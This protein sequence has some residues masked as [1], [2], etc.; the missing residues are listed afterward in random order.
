MSIDA[1]QL[2][3][4]KRAYTA[5]GGEFV[6]R[7]GLSKQA[8]PLKTLVLKNKGRDLRFGEVEPLLGVPAHDAVR[9]GVVLS[10]CR[11]AEGRPSEDTK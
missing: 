1:D 5:R 3:I 10:V 11:L 8:Q 4:S 9:D 6:K 7:Q 2:P